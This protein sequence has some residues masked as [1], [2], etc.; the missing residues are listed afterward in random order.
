M[1]K[2]PLEVEGGFG[3]QGFHKGEYLTDEIFL[4]FGLY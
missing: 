2:K 1:K 3:F 4:V